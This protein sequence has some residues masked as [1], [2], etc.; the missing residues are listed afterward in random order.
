MCAL[1]A[2]SH[3]AA[4]DRR[5]GFGSR[6]ETFHARLLFNRGMRRFFLAAAS[7]CLLF[8]FAPWLAS[9]KIVEL[10]QTATPIKAP[11]C[12]KGVPANQ[13][14]I[15]L[16]WMTAFETIS[17]GVRT[18]TKAT[19]NGYVVAL[20]VGLS[21]LSSDPNLRKQYIQ[22]LNSSYGGSPR[23]AVA[24]LQHQGS[25]GL[26]WKVV[27]MSPFI[28]VLP[29]LGYVVQ[30]PLA[31]ALPIQA[32]EY[33]ALT[34]STWAPVLSIRLPSN[35]FGYRQS[36]DFNCSNPPAR[37]DWQNVGQT[38]YYYCEYFGTRAEYTATEVTSPVPPKNFVTA[39]DGRTISSAAAKSKSA[40]GS[41]GV[42]F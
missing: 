1:C 14:T 26:H 7:C 15:I 5:R 10:G 36:R 39:Q 42:G 11:V 6:G 23:V 38:T 3:G 33:V 12:P 34:T 2:R 30:F 40:F 9:A 19:K 24:V 18:P 22:N 17:D 27:A 25:S 4:A 16:P 20:T 13:C 28:S 21:Q 29:Y 37:S 32:G 8:A 31:K 41:G 35:R